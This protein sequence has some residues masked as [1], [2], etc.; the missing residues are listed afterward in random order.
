MRLVTFE[1][2]GTARIGALVDNDRSIVDLAGADHA[3]G[4][5]NEAN[6]ATMLALIEAGPAGLEAVQA[7]IDAVRNDTLTETLVQTVAVR[8]MAPVPVPTQMRDCLV[9]EQHYR[10]ARTNGLRLRPQMLGQSDTPLAVA[11]DFTIP[12]VW[13][14]QPIYYKSN[15]L[16][17]IGTGGDVLWPR[18]CGWLDYEHE[19]GIFIGCKGKDIPAS[20]AREHIFGYTIF[21]DMSARDFQYR[22]SAGG[23][24]PAKGKDFDTGNILG[25]CIVTADEIGDPYH[26]TMTSRIN[27]EVVNVG[28]SADMHH[29]FERIIEHVSTNETLYPG[30]FLGSGTVG[31]GCGLERDQWLRPGDVVELEIS[32]IGVLRNKVTDPLHVAPKFRTEGI[33]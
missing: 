21:N 10:D 15:R 3:V 26:L 13:F 23:L 31:G 6:F 2:S 29:T 1:T 19:F 16:S 8:L 24:G 17:V 18:G 14:E 32:D 5:G 12:D 30:E 25:P 11:P 33:R 7:T 28:S 9:F 22:E 27:G 20:R 4:G